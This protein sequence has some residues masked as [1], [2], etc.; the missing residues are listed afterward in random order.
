MGSLHRSISFVEKKE[1][2]TNTKRENRKNRKKEKKKERKRNKREFNQRESYPTRKSASAQNWTFH[3][4]RKRRR[5]AT[6]SCEQTKQKKQKKKRKKKKR[7]SWWWLGFV[8]TFPS[9][10]K[11]S[12]LSLPIS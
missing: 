3:L 12:S 1:P 7:A 5:G 6:G 8:T 2:Q 4:A 9:V 11:Y 10:S